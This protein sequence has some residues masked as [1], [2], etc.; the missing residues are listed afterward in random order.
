[1]D[2]KR[3]DRKSWDERQDE[4]IAEWNRENKSPDVVVLPYNSIG[5]SGKTPQAKTYDIKTTK[6]CRHLSNRCL[7]RCLSMLMDTHIHTQTLNSCHKE[8]MLSS[9]SIFLLRRV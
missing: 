4:I 9:I 8:G 2:R 1:M 7:Y 6:V 5:D 3:P